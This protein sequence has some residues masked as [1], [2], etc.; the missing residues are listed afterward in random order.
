MVKRCGPTA[1]A[2]IIV[3]IMWS[4]WP[5]VSQAD[6]SPAIRQMMST[7]VSMFEFVL[8]QIYEMTKCRVSYFSGGWISGPCM[9]VFP[10][11]NFADNVIVMD[12]YVEPSYERMQGFENASEEGRK[13]ILI[14]VLEFVADNIAVSRD[15][16]NGPRF[17]GLIQEIF[18]DRRYDWL[19][20]DSEIAMDEFADR[21]RITLTINHKGKVYRARR[22]HRGEI[23]FWTEPAL[24][25]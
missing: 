15:P 17:P 2:V 14:K 10:R 9:S 7:K 8:L 13:R 20:K 6:P 21:T 23:S 25:R 3:A 5:G 24:G 16:K 1:I 4:G 22:S 11:Y 19:A 18:L 12:F